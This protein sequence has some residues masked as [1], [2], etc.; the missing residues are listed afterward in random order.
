MEMVNMTKVMYNGKIIELS[1]KLEEGFAELDM[2]NPSK[3]NNEELENTIELN[4]INLVDTKELFLGD[5]N[6]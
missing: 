3:I 1:D 6:E 5:I 2:L 4:P